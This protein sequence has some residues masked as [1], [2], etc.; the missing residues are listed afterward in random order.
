MQ[1]NNANCGVRKTKYDTYNYAT[2]I[3]NV[4]YP[5]YNKLVINPN[6]GSYKGSSE[7]TSSVKSC[8]ELETLET[9]VK[10]GYTFTGWTL[11]NGSKAYGEVNNNTYTYCAESESEDITD[12]MYVTTLTANWEVATTLNVKSYEIE[13]TTGNKKYIS[14]VKYKLVNVSDDSEIT[15]Y[16]EGID[17]L[18]NSQIVFNNVQAGTYKLICIQPPEGYNIIVQETTITITEGTN[19]VEIQYKPKL[20]LPSVRKL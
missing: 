2:G 6:G 17:S 7:N 4:N 16:V 19:E 8:I 15:D 11:T 12:E 5:Y 10:T 13:N 1:V 3:I 14:G 9:P 18:G 20:A